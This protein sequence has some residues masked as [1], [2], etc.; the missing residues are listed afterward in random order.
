MVW[1]CIAFFLGALCTT[2]MVES[3]NVEPAIFGTFQQDS[4]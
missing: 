1:L 2:F 3:P 4:A